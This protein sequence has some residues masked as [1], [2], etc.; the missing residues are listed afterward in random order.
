MGRG[1]GSTIIYRDRT[2]PPATAVT[3]QTGSEQNGLPRGEL[4]VRPNHDRRQPSSAKAE[5]IQTI[6]RAH[7]LVAVV[8]DDIVVDH[9]RELGL[10]VLHDVDT[11]PPS[12]NSIYWNRRRSRRP[13]LTRRHAAGL[14]CR[15]R[16]S[17]RRSHAASRTISSGRPSLSRSRPTPPLL[18]THHLAASSR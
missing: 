8:D 17:S 16:G 7:G 3:P 18:G 5:I 12:G 10:P 1:R 6:S 13:N 15:A 11:G 4:H 14:L 9:L 2:A